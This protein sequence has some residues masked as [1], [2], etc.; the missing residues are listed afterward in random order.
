MESFIT[1]KAEQRSGAE[2]KGKYRKCPEVVETGKR[3]AS[4]SQDRDCHVRAPEGVGNG[5][6]MCR[7]NAERQL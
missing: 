1:E 7:Y 3:C 4:G 6:E 5:A 2:C